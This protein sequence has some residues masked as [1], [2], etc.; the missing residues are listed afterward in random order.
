MIIKTFDNGWGPE[1]ELKKFEAE[2]LKSYLRPIMDNTQRWIVINSTWYTQDYHQE[3]LAQLRNLEF[4]GIVL[5]AFIDAAIPM[6]EWYSEFDCPVL[7]VGYYLGQHQIDFWAL[8]SHRYMDLAP[9][10]NL[11]DS[12]EIDTAYMCL[13]R[14]PHGHRRQLYQQLKS[15]DLVDRGIVSM[16]GDD[17]YPV[18]KLLDIDQGG[19]N[20]APNANAGHHG[21]PNDIASL[22]HPTNWRRHLVNVV[23][24]T[25]WDIS[26]NQFVSEKIFKPLLGQRPFLVYDPDGASSWLSARGF[27]LYHRDFLDISDQDPALPNNVAGFLQQL[28][29]QDTLYFQSKF[30]ALQEKIMY[31]HNNFHKYVAEQTKKIS[32]GIL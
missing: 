11:Q 10:G 5:V 3:V 6:V 22:G 25:T 13:N 8:M 17:E 20:I 12:A 7:P 29:W 23:T 30:I 32:Q 26:Q 21:M 16:G 27:E 4:D 18:Q 9:Y 28:C 19:T 31:N 14:K 1:L 15:L 24:E 2:I